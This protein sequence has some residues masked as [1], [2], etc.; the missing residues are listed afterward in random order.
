MARVTSGH[1]MFDYASDR[2]TFKTGYSSLD[3]TE[4]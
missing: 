1:S 3:G 4:P 2:F